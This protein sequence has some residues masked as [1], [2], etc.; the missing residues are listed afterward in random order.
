[1]LGFI[2]VLLFLFY[3]GTKNYALFHTLVEWITLFIG[4]IMAVLAMNTYKMV[5]S[6]Q[7]T[8]LG[9]AYGFISIFYCIH[10]LSLSEFNLFPQ[11]QANK[12]IQLWMVGRYMECITLLVVC[13]SFY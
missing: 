10:A 4:I 6:H 7:L 3:L 13:G 8:Y 5:S 1:I 2:P 11:L 12:S 9:I